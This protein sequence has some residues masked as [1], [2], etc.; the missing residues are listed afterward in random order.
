MAANWIEDVVPF[1]VMLNGLGEAPV[2]GV[3]REPVDDPTPVTRQRHTKQVLAVTAPLQPM[4]AA[5]KDA[6]IGFHHLTCNGGA[7]SFR[8]LDKVTGLT[9]LYSWRGPP[10]S[11]AQPDGLYR[12]VLPLWVTL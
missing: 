6:V 5:M 9:K 2:D 12:V 4:T 10:Q 11:A 1:N 7:T 3:I 8:A